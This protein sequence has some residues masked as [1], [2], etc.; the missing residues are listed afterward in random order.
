MRNI[1][2]IL[3]SGTGSRCGTDIPKQFLKIEDKM[4]LEY[5]IDAFEQNEVISDIIVV[6]SKEYFDTVSELIPKYKKFSKVVVGGATRKDSSYNGIFSIDGN[7]GN[8][9]IHDAA[10][11]LITSRIITD[12][13]NGL[14][15]YNAV[16]TAII[17]TDTVFICDKDKNIDNIP[18]RKNV[19]R[20]QTPQC[21]KLSVI[22]TAHQKALLDKNCSVTD[23]C[24]LVVN[25]TNEK[26]HIIEGSEDNIKVTYQNDIEFVKSKLQQK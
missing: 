11:P 5:S 6:T 14:N 10:R 8:V 18:I 20:A 26:I 17:S 19:Y 25:Y 4:I 23:D 15:M 21:F 22:K 13:I 7:D 24:G 2:L 12:C 1:A 16:C 9:L 3:A